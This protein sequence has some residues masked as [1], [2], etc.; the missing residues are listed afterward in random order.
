MDRRACEGEGAIE[1]V[2]RGLLEIRVI[3][4]EKRLFSFS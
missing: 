4:R 2:E 1:G 3:F